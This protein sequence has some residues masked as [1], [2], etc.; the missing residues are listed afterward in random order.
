MSEFYEKA[1]VEIDDALDRAQQDRSSIDPGKIPQYHIKYLDHVLYG[2]APAELVIIGADT[3]R[4]KSHMANHIVLENAKRGKKV[5]YFSLEGHRSEVINRWKWGKI[6]REYF[7]NPRGI[8]MH[9]GLYEMNSIKGIE[10][11]ERIATEELREEAKNVFLYDRKESLNVRNLT[12]KLSS[13]SD[14]D[15]IVIDHLH[16]FD[17]IDDRS[18]NDNISEIMKTVK[19]IT[20]SPER[21][22]VVLVSHLRK[23]SNLRGLPD[24]EDFMGSSNIPKIATTCILLS[25]NHENH[26]IAEGKYATIVRV[27]KSRAGASTTVAAEMFFDSRSGTYDDAYRFGKVVSGE[28]KKLAHEEWPYWARQERT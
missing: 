19:S 27:S 11:E 15:L 12:Q 17:M 23:K 10:E 5:Y 3:G 26:D 21:T 28:Y 2:I 25:P 4:G 1:F 8:K 18:E 6:C 22:P 16:Y 13:V 24:N 14:A 9:F 7:K 20:E